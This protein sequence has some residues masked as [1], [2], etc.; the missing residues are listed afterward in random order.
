[1]VIATA[2]WSVTAALAE[3]SGSATLV[4]VTVIVW[5]DPSDPGGVYNP[6]V[7]IVPTKGLRDQITEVSDAPFTEAVNC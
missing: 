4:A 2:G 7:E 6:E 3:L 1:M 5:G